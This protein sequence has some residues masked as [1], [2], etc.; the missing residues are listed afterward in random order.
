MTR[1]D[2]FKKLNE[3]FQDVFDDVTIR[4][5]DATCA[6]DIECW[7]SLMHIT[8]ISEVEEA[9]DIHFEMKDKTAMKTV[10]EMADRILE[11]IHM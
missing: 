6:E 9:F 1:E 3:V 2:V 10:G 5:N 11:L 8:L 7:D 4:V